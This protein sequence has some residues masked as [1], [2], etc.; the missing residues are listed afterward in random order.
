MGELEILYLAAASAIGLVVK[1]SDFQLAQQRLYAA[2]RKSG[3]PSLDCLQLRR[4]PFNPESE[5]W[6]VKAGKAELPKAAEVS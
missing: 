6:I 3:D 2:R 4:S 1:V 5:L